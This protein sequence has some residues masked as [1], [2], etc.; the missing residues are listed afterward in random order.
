MKTSNRATN[1]SSHRK[2]YAV[3]AAFVVL[4][5]VVLIFCISSMSRNPVVTEFIQ[6]SYLKKTLDGNYGFDLTAEVGSETYEIKENS[7]FVEVLDLDSWVE[8]EEENVETGEP[9][10]ALN[11]GST[12]HYTFYS[13]GYVYA[14][15]SGELRSS[16]L[17]VKK[18]TQYKTAAEL[19]QKLLDYILQNGTEPVEDND[20]ILTVEEAVARVRPL[21]GAPS[22]EFIE[23]LSQE[24]ITW[25]QYAEKYESTSSYEY[26]D[27]LVWVLT[28]R[29]TEKDGAVVT[30]LATVDA[31]IGA[32]LESRP[33]KD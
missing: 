18:D 17:P 3:A 27:N 8:T 20:T 6:V 4:I 16:Y 33:L 2:I 10:V 24:L 11:F 31:V 19:P 7:A 12:V 29:Y 25:A 28:I 9:L 14:L 13:G 26:P 32:P 23:V 1:T 22:I 30:Q 15:Y 21:L 5:V